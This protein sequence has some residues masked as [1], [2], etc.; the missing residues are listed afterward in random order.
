MKDSEIVRSC[1]TCVSRC[2]TPM[3]TCLAE[4]F[5]LYRPDFALLARK[6]AKAEEAPQKEAEG[7]TLSDE[8]A[9][10]YE[11][12][13]NDDP[14]VK[15]R[16]EQ[17]RKWNATR[18]RK[19]ETDAA[20]AEREKE[21]AKARYWKDPEKARSKRKESY[22]R[23]A[24]TEEG[25]AAINA[26]Q[27]NYMRSLRRNNPEKHSEIM[28]KKKEYNREYYRNQTDEQRLKHNARSRRNY[29]IKL[30]TESPEE[31][32][33]RRAKDRERYRRRLENMDPEER[34]QYLDRKNARKRE[35]RAMRRESNNRNMQTFKK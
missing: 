1:E 32:E 8:Q 2:S 17:S 27:R 24:S 35:L 6:E 14:R 9:W 33:A 34:K 25:R 10:L 23:Q 21:L 4:N 12:Y 31:R 30:A 15:K 22:S 20:Y 11:Q 16:K 5:L 26:R 19:R 29:T 7:N 28:Q 18:Q 13:V 3:K